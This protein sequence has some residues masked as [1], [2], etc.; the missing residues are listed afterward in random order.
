M[1]KK[2]TLDAI[3]DFMQ[4]GYG[5]LNKSFPIARPPTSSSSGE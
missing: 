4:A 5:A 3:C 1:K 2:Y